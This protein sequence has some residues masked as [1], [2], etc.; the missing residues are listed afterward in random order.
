MTTTPQPGPGLP[1]PSELRRQA[2]VEAGPFLDRLDLPDP[3]DALRDWTR[4]LA[5]AE[6]PAQFHVLVDTVTGTHD[7]TLQGLRD[8]LLT[9]GTWCREHGQ[10]R[11]GERYQRTSDL[12]DV[13]DRLLHQLGVD[14][15]AATWPDQ[16]P[17][18]P[19]PGRTPH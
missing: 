16:A 19:S 10:A 9:A 13:A 5:E 12:L 18:A 8:F 4:R 6:R 3:A 15:L 1:S 17:T 14:H 7:S 2:R 11:L